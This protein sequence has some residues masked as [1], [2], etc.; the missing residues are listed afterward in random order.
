MCWYIAYLDRI[1]IVEL[2]SSRLAEV[3]YKQR[4]GGQRGSEHGHFETMVEEIE[5]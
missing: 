3:E 5:L 1:G 2:I 4:E